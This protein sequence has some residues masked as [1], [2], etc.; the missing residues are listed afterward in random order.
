MIGY[1]FL[2]VGFVIGFMFNWMARIFKKNID[3]KTLVIIKS[4]G[5]MFI[6][7]GCIIIF[8]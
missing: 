3:E 5:L 2:V 4:L 7:A 1:V 8:I 6:V